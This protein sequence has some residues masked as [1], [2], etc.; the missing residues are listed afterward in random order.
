MLQGTLPGGEHWICLL[1]VMLFLL[2]I[3][4]AFSFVEG[5]L[6]V[7]ADT[8]LFHGVSRKKS[9]FVLAFGAFLLS[10]MYATDAGLIFLDTIDYYIN[11]VMLLVGGFECFGAGWVYG[12]EKQ[13]ENLG[14][15]IVFTHITAYF[16]AVIV[17]CGLWFGL[18]NADDALWADFVG[19]VGF[20]VLGMTVVALL[21]HL[22][23]RKQPGRWTWGSITYEL[24]FRNIADLKL[25][26]SQVVG[27]LPFAWT[28]LVKYFIPPVILILFGLACDA[29]N[30]DGTKVFGHYKGYVTLPYQV[31]GI[32]C[33]AFTG[34][35]FLSSLIVPQMYSPLQRP[36]GEKARSVHAEP[37]K[38]ADVKKVDSVDESADDSNQSK[39]A[40]PSESVFQA[41]ETENATVE[42]A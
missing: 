23:M 4:S 2:G 13:I 18:S 42:A 3:D 20:Y 6:T 17:A 31:L 36:G 16:G 29:E 34:F 9:S 15:A 37:E 19:L 25:D 39:P 35:L 40:T 12:T 27:Y 11:F 8:K 24:L 1:F 14:A 22:R 38:I 10:L 32:L 30:A 33:V 28:L 41:L 7:L 21:M 5:F 26:L